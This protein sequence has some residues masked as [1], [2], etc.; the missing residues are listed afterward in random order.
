MGYAKQSVDGVP[1]GISTV[2]AWVTNNDYRFTIRWEDKNNAAVLTQRYLGPRF[3]LVWT[4][5]LMRTS[6]LS[7]VIMVMFIQRM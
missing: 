2:P 3:V 7:Q 1:S 4:I 5:L 6:G